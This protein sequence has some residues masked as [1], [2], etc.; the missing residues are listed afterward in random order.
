MSRLYNNFALL[1][2]S[3]LL[4]PLFSTALVLAIARLQGVEMLGKY[5]LMMTVFGVGQI[6][7]TLGVP[8]IITRE[9][10]RDHGTASR[11]LMNACVVVLLLLLAP[12]LLLMAGTAVGVSDAAMRV[13]LPLVLVGL[14][15]SVFIS[16]CEAVLLGLERATD[17]VAVNLAENLLR[18]A[19]GAGLVVAG[20]GVV[21]LAALTVTLRVLAALGFVAM[22]R[23]RGVSSVAPLDWPWCR[24]L[25]RALPVLG[26]IPVVN[27]FYARAEVFALTLFGSW[28]QVGLYSA[29]LRI[30]DVT[31]TLPPAFGR[32]LYPI[33][34]RVQSRSAEDFA[35]AAREALHDILFIISPATMLVC[36]LAPHI[37]AF[38]YGAEAAGAAA[39]LAI[40]VWALGPLSVA[41]VLAQA[42]FAANRQAIDLRV[43]AVGLVAV[44]ILATLLVPRWGR[45][46]RRARWWRRPACTRRCSTAG[47]AAICSIRAWCRSSCVSSASQ[48]PR[49]ER[50]CSASAHRRSARWSPGAPCTRPSGGSPGSSN[51]ATCAASVW[52]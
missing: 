52:H 36:A 17:L 14:V 46:G 6:C 41:T 31:R 16:F 23:W 38:L 27:A 50:R 37:T 48:R 3:S 32:A 13:A 42:L 10:A 33:L 43:N 19:A 8:V 40:L 47:C 29:A 18:A 49:P 45:P 15:P 12:L 35:T 25:L 11:C 26:A 5:S 30:V 44:V 22:L 28:E 9:V 7:A 1:T 21:A 51:R 39:P 4:T 34:A 2:A 24:D 20:H